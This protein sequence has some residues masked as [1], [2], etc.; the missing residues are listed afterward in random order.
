MYCTFPGQNLTFAAPP[1]NG[2][3]IRH[4]RQ[5]WYQ[6]TGDAYCWR[7]LPLAAC[8]GRPMPAGWPAAS[9]NWLRQGRAQRRTSC[10]AWRGQRVAVCRTLCDGGG[11][12]CAAAVRRFSDS[13][14]TAFAF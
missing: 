1:G 10:R 8:E 14:E 13:A 4:F 7:C 2:I 9:R 6:S 5:Q 11:R 3:R 12:R